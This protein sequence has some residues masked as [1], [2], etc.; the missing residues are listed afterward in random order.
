LAFGI[1]FQLPTFDSTSLD[2]AW[3]SGFVDA[4][5]SFEVDISKKDDTVLDNFIDNFILTDIPKKK[6]SDTFFL[7]LDVLFG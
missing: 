1:N 6:F 2:N 7:L 3:L 4:D 5:G